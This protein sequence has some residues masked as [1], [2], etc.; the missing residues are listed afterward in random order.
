MM[1]SASISFL[2]VL[3]NGVS[4][5]FVERLRIREVVYRTHARCELGSSVREVTFDVVSK[6]RLNQ[7]LSVP[8]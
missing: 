6:F 8:H 5:I 1:R 7:G 4:S 2:L 3:S